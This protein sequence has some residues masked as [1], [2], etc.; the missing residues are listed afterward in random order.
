MKKKSTW[1][2]LNEFTL[3]AIEIEGQH[4]TPNPY[5]VKLVLP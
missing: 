3:Q 2:L 4:D 5:L 1:N